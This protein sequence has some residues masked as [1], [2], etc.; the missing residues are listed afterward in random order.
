VL[1]LLLAFCTWTGA[2]A[3]L[4]T[5]ASVEELAGHAPVRVAADVHPNSVSRLEFLVSDSEVKLSWQM[6]A[7][8]LME[9]PQVKWEGHDLWEASEDEARTHWPEIKPYLE[10]GFTIE[11]DGEP[12]LVEFDAYEL[13]EEGYAFFVETSL[14][15]DS[16]PTAITLDVQH[17][18]EDGNRDHIMVTEVVGLTDKVDRYFMQHHHRSVAFPLPL[19]EE[20]MK[21]LSMTNKS[22]LAMYLELGWEH[23]LEGVDHLAFVLALLFGVATWRA[24]FSAVTAFTLAHSITLALAAFNVLTLPASIVEPG[25]ALSVAIVLWWHLWKGPSESKAWKPAFGFGLLHGCGF[26]GVLGEIGIPEDAAVSA[27]LGFNLGV[28]VGQLTFV[29][30]VIAAGLFLNKVLPADSKKGALQLFALALAAF[31]CHL[32]GVASTSY[33]GIEFG[34]LP[35]ALQ[36]LPVMLTVSVL[37]ALWFRNKQSATG[38]AMPRSIMS[39]FV[40]AVLYETGLWL[41]G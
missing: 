15:V 17:F 36:S 38:D 4:P 41:G 28:E 14:A 19:T 11:I 29:I 33:I 1:S 20:E 6:Q 8:T 22:P 21:E 39:A 30:P 2:S 24:L 16:K 12:W 5:A 13:R 34:L 31:A 9:V 32:I 25:I 10:Q 37:L 26:A 7:R 40:L 35:D 23:V 18:F 3:I 27:L